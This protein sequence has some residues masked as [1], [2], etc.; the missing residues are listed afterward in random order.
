MYEY[1]HIRAG[2]HRHQK[3]ALDSPGSKVRGSY[4]LPYVST[5]DKI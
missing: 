3:Q 2:V 4:E 1:A 5:W